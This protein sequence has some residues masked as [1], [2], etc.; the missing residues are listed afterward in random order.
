MY[1]DYD[2]VFILLDKILELVEKIYSW[3]EKEKKEKSI[4]LGNLYTIEEEEE[5]ENCFKDEFILV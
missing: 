1:N 2:A 5:E 4:E 3:S